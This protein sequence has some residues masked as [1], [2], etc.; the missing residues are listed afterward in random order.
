MKRI[1]SAVLLACVA[2]GTAAQPAAG[3]QPPSDRPAVANPQLRAELLSRTRTDQQARG[4]LI[5]FLKTHGS[6]AALDA[7]A[8]DQA[9]Q[10]QW[11]QLTSR[12]QKIDGDNTAWLRQLVKQHGW[13]TI[14]MVGQDGAQ[15]AWL[16]VQHADAQP[17][18]QR[19]CLDLMTALPTEQVSQTN[20]A[21]LTDRVR[22]AEGK[23]QVYG[24]QFQLE[25][26]QWK[27]RHLEDEAHVDQRRARVGLPPLAEYIKQLQAM[28]GG[29]QG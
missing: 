22:L 15:A 1:V 29:G 20:L 24:T 19:E 6:G 27:P 17:Q 10:T 11:E 26:G 23:P 12:L 21:Y 9:E 7:T 13:P 8:L 3:S 5:A 16:L 25:D 14:A 2:L 4:A 28:Y 18:F